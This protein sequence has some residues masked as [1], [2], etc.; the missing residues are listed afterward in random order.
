M[1]KI[2]YINSKINSF[3]IVVSIIF[4]AHLKAQTPSFA[5]ETE[6]TINGLTFDAMEPH[7]STDGNALFFN[8][9]N[10]GI[11]TSLYYAARVN[12]SVFNFIGLVPI[13]NQTVS[14]RLDG[15]ASIDTANN[16]YWVS[17]RN[18][19]N[20]NLHRIR[21]LT[22]SFTNFGLVH[23]D[24]YVSGSGWL[25]MDAA[26]NHYGDKLIYCN[27]W[28]NGCLGGAPC[29]SAM[30]IAQKVND[31]TFNKMSNS[32][33]WFADINDTTD[34][35]VYAPFL[36]KDELELYYTRLLKNGTQTE[37]MV[38]TRANV[39]DPFGT[40]SLLISTPSVLPE[41]PALTSDQTKMY[42]HKKIGV[43]FKI[44]YQTRV[45]AIK[46]KELENNSNFSVHPNPANN[47]ISID[48]LPTDEKY[49]IEIHSILGQSVLK[50][51]NENKINISQLENGI[52]IIKIITSTGITSNFK[53]VKE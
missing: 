51:T 11:T 40:P 13:V 46:I 24:F 26:I 52:Y 10:D 17:A 41:G 30:G 21:F 28:F 38:A 25:I 43:T 3:L 2:I 29:I 5:N 44:Y 9:L 22:S 50:K 8:S 36:S 14:P 1:R 12:D 45:E 16:F 6:V 39:N 42:Y 34:Y 18:L 20:E 37:I 31:S 27:A 32:D 7:L 47:E 23:G 19:P 48:N 15:V 35:I 4:C 33:A 49:T 53:I